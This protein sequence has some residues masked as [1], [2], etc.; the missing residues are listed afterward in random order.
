MFS[1]VSKQGLYWTRFLLSFC[2]LCLFRLAS[3][4]TRVIVRVRVCVH[5]CVRANDFS[6]FTLAA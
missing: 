5:V 2:F 6:R 3:P 1:P 4:R